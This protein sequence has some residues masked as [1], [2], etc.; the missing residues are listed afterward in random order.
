MNF[1]LKRCLNTPLSKSFKSQEKGNTYKKTSPEL[2]SI[3]NEKTIIL[4]NSCKDDFDS[5]GMNYI[6]KT[7]AS[8]DAA[9][10]LEAY[11]RK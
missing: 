4:V 3:S 2:E 6:R 11:I 10:L 7:F 9:L 5:T 8:S 1:G